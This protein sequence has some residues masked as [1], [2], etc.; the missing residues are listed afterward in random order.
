MLANVK[1]PCSFRTRVLNM[2]IMI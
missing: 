2:S 1:V